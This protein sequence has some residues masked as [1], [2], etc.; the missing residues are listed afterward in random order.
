MG[1]S[2]VFLD[3]NILVYLLED[4]GPLGERAGRIFS[5]LSDRGDL[6]MFSS[7]TVG[8]ILVKPKRMN[9][10]ILESQ[11]RNLFDSPGTQVF[12]FDR[13]AAELFALIRVNRAIK[14][15][16]AIQLATAASSKCDLFI[17]ND[18]RLSEFVMPGIE[19]VVSMEK[20]PF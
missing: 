11:Y 1:M 14:A 20:A 4:S 19:F 3:T 9:N 15:P 7:M 12:P 16:D 6:L 18:E 10:V 17:T 8:E 13:N 2:R 5:R